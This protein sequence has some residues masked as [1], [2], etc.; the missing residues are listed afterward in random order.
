MTR[1]SDFPDALPKDYRLHWYAIERVLG[2]GGFGITYLAHDSNL[3]QHVAIKEYL[4]VDMA[5]RRDDATVRARTEDLAERYQGGLERFIREARTLARFDH[6]NIVRV[7]SVFEFN[8]TAYMVMRFE[9]GETLAALLERRHALNESELM[10]ILLPIL[11]GLELVHNAGFIHRD[12]KPDNIHIRSD[13][14]PVL[15]DFGSARYAAGHARTVT[16]LVAPGYAPF[17]QYYSNGE[18]QGPWTDLYGLAA[19]CYRAIAGRPPLDAIARSKGILG[20]TKEMLVPAVAVGSSRYS[21][22]FLKA[23]DHALAFAECERPQSIAE[24]RRELQDGDA[25]VL[26]PATTRIRS[27][28]PQELVAA[29]IAASAPAPA[30]GSVRAPL[31][32]SSAGGLIVLAAAGAFG[33]WQRTPPQPQVAVAAPTP[34]A[35]AEDPALN[36]RLRKLEEQLASNERRQ[37][38]NAR[39][40]KEIESLKKQLEAARRPAPQAAPPEVPK[41]APEAAKPK[42]EPPA[43]KRAPAPK[44]GPAPKVEPKI[45]EPPR[46]ALAPTPQPEVKQAPA[47][48]PTAAPPAPPPAA[49]PVE[50][51][52]PRVPTTAEQLASADEALAKGAHRD[53]LSILQ[54]L[55]QR[56][57]VEAEAKLG[58]LYLDGRGVERNA[59]EALRLFRSAAGKGHADAQFR[60]G[61]IYEAGQAVTQSYYL[62]Y[63]WYSVA[64]RHGHGQANRLRMR[65]GPRLQPAEIQQADKLVDGMVGAKGG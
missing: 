13:G 51:P 58:R 42:R 44:A 48:Q 28:P 50:A 22:R 61:E 31:F 8:Q 35:P 5:T 1:N 27:Q 14:S 47:E 56:G 59:D 7:L 34:A 2:Q 29:P 15:L 37:E 60:L 18:N 30:A 11:D 9:E 36:E 26:P 10:R 32:W 40:E 49:P 20:S 55:A 65:V 12:I 64:A 39:L 19:T 16:I 6:P 4:P 23:I 54:Q 53:A 25:T 33:W 3:D 17:E 38:D 52:K 63:F 62:A 57:N 43:A 46:V 21:E 24:W 41:R 45:A